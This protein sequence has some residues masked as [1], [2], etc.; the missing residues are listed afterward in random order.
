MRTSNTI[1]WGNDMECSLGVL[2]NIQIIIRYIGTVKEC[3]H[4]IFKIGTP[5]YITQIDEGKER[6]RKGQKEAKKGESFVD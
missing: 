2:K 5:K 6:E 3:S 1:G 4:V